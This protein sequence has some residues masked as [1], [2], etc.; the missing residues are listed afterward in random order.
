MAKRLAV[1]D[2]EN[3]KM[4]VFRAREHEGLPFEFSCIRNRNRNIY[5]Q[6]A[7]RQLKEEDIKNLL[8]QN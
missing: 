8:K 1:L 7:G 5:L 2:Q 3:L 4:L 6:S